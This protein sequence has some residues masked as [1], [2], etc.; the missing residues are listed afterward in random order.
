MQQYGVLNRF[1]DVEPPPPAPQKKYRYVTGARKTEQYFRARAQKRVPVVLTSV[2]VPD[3]YWIRI[4][5]PPGSG[6][7]IRI[8]IRRL[9]KHHI[10]GLIC[11]I[12]YFN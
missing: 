2:S 3:P 9:K 4:Q 5:R 6:F 1:A 8:R 10:N 7:A 12:L 11:S